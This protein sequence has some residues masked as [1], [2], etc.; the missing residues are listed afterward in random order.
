[1]DEP[2]TSLK[3]SR[4]TPLVIIG[5]AVAIAA[6]IFAYRAFR[7]DGT[8]RAPDPATAAAP[9]AGAPAPEPEGVTSAPGPATVEAVSSN[10]LF[11]RAMEGDWVRRCAVVIDNLREGAS[12][13]RPL[14]SLAPRRPF[15][16]S[17]RA[18]R[19][20]ID[21]ASYERYDAFGDAVASVNTDA[22]A[23]LYRGMA[24]PL[25]AAYR[26]LGY[27]GASLDAAVARALQRIENAPVRDGDVVVQ[28]AGG[29]FVFED[30]RLEA[31]REVEKHLLR[32]GPRN[33]RLL[34]AKAREIREALQLPPPAAGAARKP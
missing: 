20:V 18:G 22:L 29:I 10:D 8:S 2:K 21:P 1:M 28:N 7:T 26:A 27:P 15:T 34:Q 4:A 24:R 19:T 11:R 25:E 33:T 3:R 32:M 23:G 6:A 14:A 16:V 12:P 31:L 17:E 13:R 5:L 9:S 30:Q